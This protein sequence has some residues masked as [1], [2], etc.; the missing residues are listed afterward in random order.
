M[1]LEKIGERRFLLIDDRLAH[2]IAARIPGLDGN[3]LKGLCRS[4]GVV[5]DGEIIAGMALGLWER[6]SV[7]VIFAADTPRWATRETIAKLM[8]WPFVQ[9]DCHRVTTR[10]AAS[11]RRAIRFNEGIGFKRE[12][13]IRQ[14]WGPDEDAV[15]LG[16]LRSEA[17][18]WMVPQDTLAATHEM[19]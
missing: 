7:E 15:L 19:A 13:L 4:V 10:I 3:L 8:H 14:G 6:G 17:P 11:N 9:L 2:W 5:S 1:I 12:G 18:E 16:L